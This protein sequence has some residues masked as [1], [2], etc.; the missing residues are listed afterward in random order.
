[1]NLQRVRQYDRCTSYKL[2]AHSKCACLQKGP[3]ETCNQKTE[4]DREIFFSFSQNK[5]ASKRG[6]II[7]TEEELL[8]Q[9]TA[10]S[11]DHKRTDTSTLI[12]VVYYSHFCSFLSFVT[13]MLVEL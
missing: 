2:T 8:L 4:R 9:T 5:N 10:T 12:Y 6:M 13:F 7:T 11:D 1:M 3:N